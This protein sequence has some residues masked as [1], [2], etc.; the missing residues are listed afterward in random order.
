MMGWAWLVPG[1]GLLVVAAYLMAGRGLRLPA[2]APA[3]LG[4]V[5]I[6]WCWATLGVEALG[7]FGML[8]PGPL[9][10]WSALGLA[11]AAPIAHRRGR[12][13]IGETKPTGGPWEASAVLSLGLV[14]WVFLRFGLPSLLMPVKVVSDGPIYHLYM[15]A[16]WWKAGRVFPVATPFGE[17]GA[18]YFWANG[19]AWF[20]WLMTL[21][22]GDRLARVGQIPFLVVGAMAAHAMARRLGSGTSAALIAAGWFVTLGP[23]MI[24]GCEPNVDAQFVA[25][26]LLAAYFFLRYAL[27]DD[28]ATSLALGAVAAGLT[29]GTKPTGIVFVPVLLAGVAVLI[30]ARPAPLWTRIGHLALLIFMPLLGMG[31][32]AARNAALTGNP[33]YPLHLSVFGRVI[34]RGWFEPEVMRFSVYY[35]PREDWRAFVDILVSVLDARLA[36][37]WL[38][39]I[40]GAWWIGRRDRVDRARWVWALSGLA[41]LIVALY[42]L[43]IPYRTQQRFMLPAFGLAVTPLALTLD[44]ARWLRWAGAGL[45][46]VHVLTPQPWPLSGPDDRIPWDMTPVIAN[47]IPAPITVPTGPPMWRQLIAEPGGMAQAVSLGLWGLGAM[48]VA[49]SWSRLARD[50]S[51]RAWVV[52]GGLTAAVTLG[53]GWAIRVGAPPSPFPFFR[54]YFVGWTEL[55]ARAGATGARIAY[56]G[57]NIP[58]YLMGGDLRNEVRYINIDAHRDWLMHDYHRAASSL[59]LPETWP[60]PYPG[61]DRMRPDYAAWLANLR[62]AGIEILVVARA[63]VSE[64]SHNVADAEGFPVERGW[65][66]SHPES[67]QPLY[68]VNPPDPLFR[69]YRV[70]P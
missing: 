48:A 1:V 9:T 7:S 65:A 31:Y 3:R 26:Y 62:A 6:G 33:F 8:R 60:N 69:F 4:A 11:I 64:G 35:I 51:R 70:A 16:R 38:A 13:P 41:V 2:G 45:L 32:W 55:E 39:A 5:L 58:Y 43:V 18:T 10:L 54:D 17:V 24:F 57:T 29:W 27:E 21:Q 36:P 22:G 49:W 19:E 50:G 52:A 46:A 61:W 37:A 42:W 34:L 40:G 20:A 68:G 53:S 15:A 66:E 28:G 12:I 67:F 23:L 44:R 25:G 30:V 47:A 63:N 59:G 56:A 14:I